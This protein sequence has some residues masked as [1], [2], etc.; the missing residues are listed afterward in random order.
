MVKKIMKRHLTVAAA[1]P[2]SLRQGQVFKACWNLKV[3]PT[4]FITLS[5]LSRVTESTFSILDTK[6]SSAKLKYILKGK[7]WN[8]EREIVYLHHWKLHPENSHLDIVKS[9]LECKPRNSPEIV[10]FLR[11]N[12]SGFHWKTKK[13]KN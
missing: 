11:M 1:A 5:F 8:F 9:K 12:V 10:L 13:S 4:P 6:Y 3:H 2:R 7:M